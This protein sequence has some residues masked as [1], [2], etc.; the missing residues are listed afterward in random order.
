MSLLSVQCFS[1]ECYLAVFINT[2]PDQRRCFWW[3]KVYRTSLP[4]CFHSFVSM[5][6][7]SYWF[8]HQHYNHS[9]TRFCYLSSAEERY[10]LSFWIEISLSLYHF[11]ISYIFSHCCFCVAEWISFA[12]LFNY[13]GI[14]TFFTPQT[15]L[16]RR[17]N[18]AVRPWPRL[19]GMMPPA[20]SSI[21]AYAQTALS[22]ASFVM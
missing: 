19:W 22:V 1:Y 18:L 8:A 11:S 16:A 17:R 2:P 4:T 14:F 12:H 13:N 21:L 10:H 9:V 20:M 7:P 6:F 15:V 5:Q 3:W